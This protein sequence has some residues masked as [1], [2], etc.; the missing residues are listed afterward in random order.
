[1]MYSEVCCL[2]SIVCVFYSF[3]VVLYQE[4]HEKVTIDDLRMTYMFPSVLKLQSS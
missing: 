2:S 3:V 1:M 4:V